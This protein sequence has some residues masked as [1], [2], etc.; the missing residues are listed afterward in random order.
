MPIAM[1]V[2]GRQRDD[3]TVLKAMAALEDL[4]D[5]TALAQGF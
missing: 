2:I 3:L 4:M 1:Q 5:F